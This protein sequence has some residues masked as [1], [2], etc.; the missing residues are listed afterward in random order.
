MPAS[1]GI[2]NF[3]HLHWLSIGEISDL[4][5]HAK[6]LEDDDDDARIVGYNSF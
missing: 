2:L 3:I 1:R 6:E 4:A 5:S